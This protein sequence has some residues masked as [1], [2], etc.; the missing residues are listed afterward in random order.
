MVSPSNVTKRRRSTFTWRRRLVPYVFIAPNLFIFLTFIIW[1]ALR[2]IYISFFDSMDGSQFTYVGTANYK[3]IFSD[4][5]VA[6]IA[7]N[8][9]IYVVFYMA[10]STLLSLTFA[11]V[12][13]QQKFARGFF[14]SSFSSGD[15]L[16]NCGGINLER[17]TRSQSRATQHIA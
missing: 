10:I 7:R 12:I 2:G 14:R 4:P 5:T 3:A 17:C 11:I 13:N 1:P 8:T 16:A 15:A 6:T 9:A